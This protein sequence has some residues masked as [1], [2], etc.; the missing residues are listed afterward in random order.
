MNLERFLS[1]H[2]ITENPFRAEEA[3]HDPVFDRL[4]ESRQWHPDFEKILGQID[5][6]S[7]SVIFG[8]KGSGKTAIR[9][10]MGRCV[11]KHNRK[12][13]QRRTLLVAYDDLNPVLDRIVQRR[14]REMGFN[15]ASRTSP[16][17]LLERIR[18]EDHQDAILSL[19]VTKLNDAVLGVNPGAEDAVI[20]PDDS[21]K[22]IK[23]LP[24]RARV[25]WA[26][27]TALYDQPRSGTAAQRWA[28]MRSKLRLSWLLPGGRLTWSRIGATVLLVVAVVLLLARYVRPEH[29]G[30]FLAGS[31]LAGAGSL[32]LWGLW[33]W[34]HLRLWALCRRVH[35]EMPSIE[36]SVGD[37]RMMLLE[38]RAADRAAQPWPTPGISGGPE[39]GN[40]DS[41][42]QLTR[43]L[44]DV[45]GPLG[46]TGLLVLVDRVDEPQ[47][48]SGR[49]ERMKPI[50]WPLLDNKFL[51]QE[52][53]GIKLLLPIELR[54][55]LRRES[56]DFFQEARLD[57]QNLIDRLD[58]SGATLYDLC[59]S[60]LRACRDASIAGRREAPDPGGPDAGDDIQLTDLFE[61]GVT[62]D[63]LVE[64]LDQMHQPRDA[65]KF[66][67]SV[68]L[69]HCRNVP[70]D[71][72]AFHIPRLV[73]D[74]VRRQQVQRVQEMQ[75]GLSPA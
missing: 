68:V 69:E 35:R 44:L 25:D 56:G 48:V 63:M 17:D 4:I 30:M 29:A 50:I 28:R 32:I 15:R 42:F 10:Q 34:G 23:R 55:L 49:A 18:L 60:R 57:K 73:L 66:L 2:G 1:H 71:Q 61:P 74:A 26:I 31:G 45:L 70:E 27:L 58:W 75:R 11:S 5:C 36:R 53:V 33:A 38:L 16:E 7:T 40:R 8:E 65:M 19:A 22:R 6:P 9:L 67:Y 24:R 52:M 43:R 37:L 39:P 14:S 62:R 12:N 64:S 20:L 54:H 41:R 59:S 13:P 72:A 46:Y 21:D 51:Q 3:R 47:L